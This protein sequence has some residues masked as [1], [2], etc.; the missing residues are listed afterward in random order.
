MRFP[1]PLTFHHIARNTL[2]ATLGFLL[3]GVTASQK[4]LNVSSEAQTQISQ[5][6]VSALEDL[7]KAFRSSYNDAIAFHEKNVLHRYP[8]ITQDLLNMTLIRS[9]GETERYSMDRK[10]YFLM[11][12]TSHPVLA[13]YSILSKD[14]FSTVSKQTIVELENYLTKLSKAA[15]EVKSLS[16]EPEVKTRIL[17]VLTS[18]AEYVQSV[19]RSGKT[20]LDEFERYARPLRHAIDENLYVGAEEQLIQFKEQVN[21]WRLQFPEE[22]WNQ[23]RVV[24]LSFHQGREKY[25]LTLFFKW[26]LHE[27][28]YEKR[29]VYA[30]FQSSISGAERDNAEKLALVLLTKVD[31]DLEAS[32]RIFGNP[33]TLQVDVMGPAA[34]KILKGWGKSGWPE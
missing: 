12:N 1:G 7:R 16:I 24:V 34:V 27:P 14:G 4:T 33:R 3:L 8:V 29:V 2:C 28:N 25:A 6:T 23:L 32:T 21:K 26:L 13:I 11:A 15:E 31:F 17:F 5:P 30:E 22:K 19:I 9:N 20:S 10:R 18:S